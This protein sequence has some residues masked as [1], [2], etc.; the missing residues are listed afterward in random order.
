[1]GIKSCD[2]VHSDATQL[3]LQL[4]EQV[5]VP[6]RKVGEISWMRSVIASESPHFLS[7]DHVSVA[8]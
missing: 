3:R 8:Q 7:D 1:M 4:S 5:D 2:R 6:D